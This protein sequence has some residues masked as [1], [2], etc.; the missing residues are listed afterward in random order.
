MSRR[1]IIAVLLALAILAF[2]SYIAE[3]HDAPI[4]YLTGTVLALIVAYI[5]SY[6]TSNEL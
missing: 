3:R 1:K 4:L 2:C 5:G 6:Y